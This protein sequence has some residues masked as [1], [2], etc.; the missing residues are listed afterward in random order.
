MMAPCRPAAKPWGLTMP[1]DRPTSCDRRLKPRG[2][3][4][5]D[6]GP[7]SEVLFQIAVLPCVV[8]LCL[9]V[10][11]IAIWLCCVCESYRV[12][13]RA[14]S[15][16]GWSPWDDPASIPPNC[17][18]A[19]SVWCWTTRA[20]MR[21][22]GPQPRGAR[23]RASQMPIAVRVDSSC[24]DWVRV[25]QSATVCLIHVQLSQSRDPKRCGDAAIADRRVARESPV[26]V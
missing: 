9:V 17:V 13:R 4:K 20:S 21:R 11:L 18:S 5:W 6:R 24:V 22:S 16:R 23:A 10:Y 7:K 15:E 12:C 14:H 26:R 8:S 2:P 25:W 3:W 1:C 19:R